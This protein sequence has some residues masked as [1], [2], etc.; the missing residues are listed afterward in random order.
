MGTQSTLV[1]LETITAVSWAG[2][3]SGLGLTL[4]KAFPWETPI[5]SSFLQLP[6][7]LGA[8]LLTGLCKE[9]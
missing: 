5:L 2:G 4:S 3:C 6:L 9:S 1:L 7:F 8:G